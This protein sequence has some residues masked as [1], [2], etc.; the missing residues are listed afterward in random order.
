MLVWHAPERDIVAQ[1]KAQIRGL[2]LSDRC[3][4]SGAWR[5]RLM[6]ILLANQNSASRR[7]QAARDH[8]QQGA[9]AGAIGPDDYTPFGGFDGE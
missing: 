8:R 3:N 9:F 7:P 6:H 2:V 1:T 4:P 5:L